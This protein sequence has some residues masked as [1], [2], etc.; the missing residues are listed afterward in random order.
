MYLNILSNLYELNSWSEYMN[1]I[2]AFMRSTLKSFLIICLFD[3]SYKRN[4]KMDNKITQNKNM[5][6][7][8]PIKI[9]KLKI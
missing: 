8:L 3:Y 1:D 9:V 5:M 4:L 6:L 2:F 7:Y